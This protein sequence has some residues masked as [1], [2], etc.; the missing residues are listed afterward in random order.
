[1]FP[2][3]EEVITIMVIGIYDDE[4]VWTNKIADYIKNYFML[5]DNKDYDIKTFTSVNDLI[6]EIAS[7]NLL[8]LDVELNNNM[9]GFDVAERIQEIDAAKPTICFFTSHIEFAR[10]GYRFNAFRYIDKLHFEEIDEAIAAY[11][12]SVAKAEYIDCKTS[13]GIDYRLNLAEAL[14]I[15]KRDRKVL[16]HMSDGNIYYGEGILKDLAQKYEKVGLIQVQ[17]SFIVNMKYIRSADSREVIIIDGTE[18]TMGR[19]KYQNFKKSYFEW[20]RK[21]M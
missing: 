14:Y 5:I 19:E 3:R 7:I 12:S 17:R 8:F 21:S 10:Q 15:E 4:I 18:I 11:I 6:S 20:R 9:S 13:D 1:M 16:F 2:Y